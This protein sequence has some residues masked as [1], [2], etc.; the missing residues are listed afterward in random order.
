M[1]EYI[2]SF[3]PDTI[4]NSPHKRFKGPALLYFF[5]NLE[6]AVIYVGQTRGSMRTRLTSHGDNRTTGFVD[7]NYWGHI[8]LVHICALPPTISQGELD[9][10]EARLIKEFAPEFNTCH[11]PRKTR[12]KKQDIRRLGFDFAQVQRIVG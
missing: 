3:P 10:I 11:F 4:I 7:G 6:G 8:A 2:G 1:I 9:T 5:A 12:R